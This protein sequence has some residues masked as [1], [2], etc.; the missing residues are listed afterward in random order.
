MRPF[1][2]LTKKITDSAHC[3]RLE[4]RT[5][6]TIARDCD[7]VNQSLRSRLYGSNMLQKLSF[8]KFRPIFDKYPEIPDG[9]APGKVTR[10]FEHQTIQV[11]IDQLKFALI[12]LNG[13]ASAGPIC[14]LFSPH[15]RRQSSRIATAKFDAEMDHTSV[16]LPQSPYFIFVD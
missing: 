6:P 14:H 15:G 7:S 8:A 10:G 9:S 2:S 4:L 5:T 13:G 3:S 12:Q 11:S 16:A 1:C